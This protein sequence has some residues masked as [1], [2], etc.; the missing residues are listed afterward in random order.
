MTTYIRV[1]AGT[2]V[3]GDPCYAVPDELWDA[4]CDASQCF[5]RPTA[6]VS[7]EG[8][9]Y[10]VL[11]FIT[12]YGDGMYKGSNGRTYPVDAGL[13]G[14]VPIGLCRDEAE[15][16]PADVVTFAKSTLCTNTGGRMTFGEIVI[17]TTE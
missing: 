13:I 5:R 8:T 7:Y 9:E 2:Y 4:A 10:V 14:L 6:R 3:L 16:R 1:P 17:D 15:R 11:G 12:A